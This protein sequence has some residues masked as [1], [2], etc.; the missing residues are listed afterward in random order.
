MNN[1]KINKTLFVGR[2]SP[3]V[4]DKDIAKLFS[5]YGTVSFIAVGE[6][7]CEEGY[8]Y[9]FVRM[10][11]VEEAQQCLENLNNKLLNREKI[12]LRF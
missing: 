1:P 9:C 6:D 10:S 7:K 5:S 8:K 2:L 11:T 4:T 12:S 3:S